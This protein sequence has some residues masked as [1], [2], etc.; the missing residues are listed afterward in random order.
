MAG[1]K[2]AEVKTDKITE[3]SFYVMAVALGLG[4]IF[5]IGFVIYALFM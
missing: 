5:T 1:Q 2:N 3:Y 4:F